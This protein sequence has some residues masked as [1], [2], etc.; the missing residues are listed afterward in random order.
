MAS[1]SEALGAVGAQHEIT[2]DGEL[3][4]FN[5]IT[6]R[7]KSELERWMYQRAMKGITDSKA[8]LDQAPGAFGDALAAITNSLAAGKYAW[9][10][11]M[12]VESLGTIAGICKIMSLLSLSMDT[13]KQVPTDKLEG[14]FLGDHSA[15]ISHLFTVIFSE[16]MPKKKVEIQETSEDQENKPNS[17]R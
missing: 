14:W 15:E 11:P 1:T 12:M 6:Q 16:S 4:K 2:I 8:L 10:G 5:L 7:V 17:D 3:I 9:G 13:H